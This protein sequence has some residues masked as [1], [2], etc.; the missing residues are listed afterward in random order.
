MHQDATKGRIATN[1]DRRASILARTS[2]SQI[3]LHIDLRTR[4][5]ID[6][7]LKSVT[8]ACESVGLRP[9]H[10]VCARIMVRSA[11]LF[12][13]NYVGLLPADL[14]EGILNSAMMETNSFDGTRILQ[15]EHLMEY[16][17]TSIRS[18]QQF[19]H[20]KQTWQVISYHDR[21]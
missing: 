12:A 15:H 11:D 9:E 20:M 10:T 5:A 1:D 3:A 14:I 17:N 21:I 2:I 8:T 6:R 19:S 13:L 16:V 7:L 18:V 4:S